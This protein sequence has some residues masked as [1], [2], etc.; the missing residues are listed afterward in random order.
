M[1]RAF[2]LFAMI[3]TV[4]ALKGDEPEISAYMELTNALNRAISENGW[5]YGTEDTECV[6]YCSIGDNMGDNMCFLEEIITSLRMF[7]P[8]EWHRASLSSGN[9]NNP[10]MVAL[11][12]YFDKAVLFTPTIRQFRS[13]VKDK[14]GRESEVRV[15]HEKLEYTKQTWRV[16][17][18]RTIHCFLGI[19]VVCPL[20]NKVAAVTYP[21]PD[22]T[23]RG[24]AGKESSICAARK[25]VAQ[26]PDS[27]I[28][29]KLV[30]MRYEKHEDDN[31]PVLVTAVEDGVVECALG[32]M[33]RCGGV[34][35][36]EKVRIVKMADGAGSEHKHWMEG[37]EN[38]FHPA[39]GRSGNGHYVFVDARYHGEHY[40]ARVKD[41]IHL[42]G[43]YT[44][45]ARLI[46]D[47]ANLIR[48][49]AVTEP[50]I[51]EAFRSRASSI[52]GSNT[53][54]TRREDR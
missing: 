27:Y 23:R 49:L 40:V 14:F 10:K 11:R 35:I 17:T 1:K 6:R 41:G 44:V 16:V 8:E 31:K 37:A 47:N 28:L 43:S 33:R 50:D 21:V 12:P 9:V 38:D 15:S 51:I 29:V 39:A 3:F 2:M 32:D 52:H 54:N 19:T 34:K 7:C 48:G 30:S 46:S 24:L 20:T 18:D 26:L 45:P 25:I 13:F 4:H 53:E 36:G 42:L 22:V 5:R